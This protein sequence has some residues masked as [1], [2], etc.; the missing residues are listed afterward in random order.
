MKY[1]ILTIL[2]VST[3][4]NTSLKSQNELKLLS[5]WSDSSLIGSNA[6]NN[7][8]NEVW[9]LA[10]NNSEFAVVGSTAGTH[11]INITNPDNIFEAFFVE[12][13]TSGGQ[14]IHRDYH[15]N[16]GFLYAVADE[17]A[18]STMQI[19]DIQNLPNSINVVYDSNAFIRRTHN[20]FI[21]SSSNIM[22]ACISSGTQ[23]PFARLRTFDIS[24]PMNPQVGQDYASVDGFFF[25]QVHDAFVIRDTAYLNCGPGGFALVDFS[26]PADP[27]LLYGLSPQD[28]PQSGYNH[29]GWLSPDGKTYV[30][31]DENHGMDMKVFDATNKNELELIGLIN[32]G[33]DSD[34]SIPHNQIIH[35]NY[36][37]ASYYY[38]GIQV[39]DIED[40]T[41]V[42]RDFY[43]E[44]SSIE[45]RESYEGAWGVYPFLP[46]GNIL[47]SDMQTGLFVLEGPGSITSGVNDNY[48]NLTAEIS[49]NPNNGHF[50]VN[51]TRDHFT[52]GAHLDIFD[53]NG[54]K[55][56]SSNLTSARSTIDIEGLANASYYY[57]LISS[58]YRKTGK[59]VVIQ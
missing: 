36:L 35:G 24:D 21:D 44:T 58:T 56:F 11:F 59:L 47:V 40:P 17:G 50:D 19:I 54:Q 52:E 9:G 23:L 32:A 53:T 34:F 6:F 39:Y 33:S 42:T 5:T 41:N 30:M 16:Q 14:I 55:V 22:Y 27:E 12:G 37:Y 13:G 2:L 38:D 48:M 57:T 28:Y 51:I 8:Y 3:I 31:A 7:I 18:N 29:S 46:S 45:H 4:V 49:P 15:D 43:Y 20:I 25:Q 1:I 10:V 26:N